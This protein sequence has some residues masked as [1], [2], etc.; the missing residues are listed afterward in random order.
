[1]FDSG[2][3]DTSTS[4]RLGLPRQTVQKWLY[5]YR[6]LG[7]EALFVSTKKY[8]SFEIKL[9]AVKAFCDEGISKLEIMKKYGIKGLGPLDSWIRLYRFGGPEA[10]RPKKRGRISNADKLKNATREEILEARVLELEL[11]LE[12]QKR[13]NALADAKKRK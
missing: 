4:S 11:E 1:M 9:A 6:A 2:F 10:L 13:I 3:G 12:I 8:Y 7:K 5:T